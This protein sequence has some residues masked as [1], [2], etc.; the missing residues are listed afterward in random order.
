MFINQMRSRI[1]MNKYDRGPTEESSGGNALKFYSSVRIKLLKGMVESV[2]AHSAITGKNEKKPI[3]VQVK[4]MIV[5]NKIDRPFMAGPIFIRFGEGF[6]N[7]YSIMELALNIG[8]IKSKG[9]FYSFTKGEEALFNV[10]GKE[11]LR[12]LLAKDNKL[13]QALRD[14]LVLKEDEQAKQEGIAE[15]EEVSSGDE[16]DSMLSNVAESFKETQAA[17]KKA[18]K[19]TDE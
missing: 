13:F 17:K 18:A 12:A 19:E 9:S 16:M 2:M 15:E 14:S 5:K 4:A 7:Y 1:K 3:N 10:Q 8:V 11:Q 6:D